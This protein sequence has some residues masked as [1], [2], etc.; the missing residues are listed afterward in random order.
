MAVAAHWYGLGLR[1]LARDDGDQPH[2]YSKCSRAHVTGPLIVNERRS[3]SRAA[4]L[5]SAPTDA[6][7]SARPRS[8]GRALFAFNAAASSLSVP[9]VFTQTFGFCEGPARCLKP[10]QLRPPPSY[11]P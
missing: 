9:R 2:A 8:Q 10:H 5:F 3:R 4:D 6:T 1:A 11:S 7:A